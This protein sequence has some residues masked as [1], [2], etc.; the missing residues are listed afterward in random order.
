MDASVVDADGNR[1]TVK[2]LGWLLRNWR[3]IES[4]IVDESPDAGTKLCAYLRHG[5][6]YQVTFADAIV[7][8]RFLHRPVFYGKPFNWYRAGYSFSGILDIEYNENRIG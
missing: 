6:C 3:R 5:G 1:R 7:L 2:N 8:W 4:F